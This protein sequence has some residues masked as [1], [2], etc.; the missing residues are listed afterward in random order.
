MKSFGLLTQNINL[1]GEGT[2]ITLLSRHFL[3]NMVIRR[4]MFITLFAEMI[5]FACKMFGLNLIM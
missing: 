5:N 4:V 1:K 2:D 3:C